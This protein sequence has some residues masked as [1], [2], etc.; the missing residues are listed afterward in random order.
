VTLTA[1][2]RTRV[3]QTVLAGSN[4]P[5]VNNVNFSLSVGTVVPTSV[6]VVEV[7]QALIEIRPEWREHMFFVVR[8][9][10][11]IIDRSH[12]IVAMVPAGSSAARLDRSGGS[13]SL[14]REEIRQ[15]QI[16]LNQKGF[17]IGTPDGVLGA[18]T[19]QALVQF[20]Q[21]QGFQATGQIDTQTVT[22]LGVSV[23]TTG[24]GGMQQPPAAQGAGQQGGQ[25]ATQPST[26]GQGGAQQP[27][28]DQG[29]A[30]QGGASGSQPSTTGQGGDRTQQP[31]A[32]QD[33]GTQGS[34]GEQGAT[35]APPNRNPESGG[36]V[37]PGGQAR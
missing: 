36:A 19:K 2:Q 5:R 28:A 18:R 7:P 26:T 23:S 17:N 11:V 21:Q 27:A 32:S 25:S 9:E 33:A 12:K 34:R 35:Q 24:Q 8:D 14:S 37:T 20:Q 13:L 4:V 29:A 22:A 15:V 30:Q 3:Q 1:E 31:S 6:R 10:I 16:A